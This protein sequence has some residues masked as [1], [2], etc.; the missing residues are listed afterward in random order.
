MTL[1]D[2][3]A[4]EN[5]GSTKPTPTGAE[6]ARESLRARATRSPLQRRVETLLE[7]TQYRIASTEAELDAVFRQR[8]DEYVAAGNLARQVE[9]LLYDDNDHGRATRVYT[10]WVDGVLAGSIRLSILRGASREG[11]TVGCWPEVVEP[12]LD[13]GLTIVDPNR[14]TTAHRLSR[15]EPALVFAV[16]R[17]AT[18]A[19]RFYGAVHCLTPIRSHHG[20][21]YRRFLHATRIGPARTFP[22]TAARMELYSVHVPTAVRR[23]D[24]GNPFL[25]ELPGES[26]ALFPSA[27][28]LG[29]AGEAVAA[30]G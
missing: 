11:L 5:G 23:A 13:D 16:L 22:G 8:H 3:D 15:T 19:A 20:A 10:A 28:E 24:G 30:T 2:T 17:L 21:F 29:L 7:R 26:A 18:M 12:M 6:A 1:D 25:L 27:A 14:L 4:A 9:P